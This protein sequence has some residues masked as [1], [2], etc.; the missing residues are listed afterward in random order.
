VQC[1]W[2][3]TAYFLLPELKYYKNMNKWM[4][5]LWLLEITKVRVKFQ[6]Y[7]FKADERISHHLGHNRIFPAD[8]IRILP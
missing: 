1:I 2:D 8:R 7:L 4:L 6:N 5:Y 3:I